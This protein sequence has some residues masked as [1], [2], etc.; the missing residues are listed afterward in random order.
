MNLKM[1]REQGEGGSIHVILR[2][3]GV[4]WEFL[5]LN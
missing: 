3:K 4:A 5:E 1:A 2:L